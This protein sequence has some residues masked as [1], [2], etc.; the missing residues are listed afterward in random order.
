MSEHLILKVRA[1]AELTPRIRSFEL[2]PTARGE[3][4]PGFTAGAHLTVHLPSGL[5]RQYSL[6]NDP[7]ERHR[8]CI[9]VQR[10]E[11]GRGG[12]REMFRDVHVGD[13]VTVG[14]PRN[15]FPLH[16]D[17]A[18]EPVL[19]AGGIGVTPILAMARRLAAAG[20]RFSMLYLARDPE[21]TAFAEEF[22]TFAAMGAEIRIH[23]DGGDPARAFDLA[24]F[25]RSLPE[26][27]HV[28]CCGPAGLMAAVAALG[29]G[30][31][32]RLH[33]EHFA[34]DDAAP[35]SGDRAFTVV[36]ARSGREIAV[37]A[38]RTILEVLLEAGLDVDYSCTE[39]TC[40][41][42][43]TRLIDGEPDHR[44]LVLLPEERDG[45]VVICCSRA[46]GERLTLDL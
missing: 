16:E 20:R 35:R 34:N 36:L 1:I 28:Y 41:T 13:A 10:E 2:V 25:F 18:G 32:E 5:E 19:I 12:S 31:G 3:T 45:N 17:D 46:K 27:A 40:G 39:G 15:H 29:E 23:H 4:L 43:I 37:P 24:G 22:S 26:A 7:A 30:R 33:F 9:A 11:D 8:Y 6:C 42:C 21:S 14:L 38:D 44:D